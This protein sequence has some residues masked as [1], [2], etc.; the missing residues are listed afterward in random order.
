MQTTGIGARPFG[1]DGDDLTRH[2]GFQSLAVS[3]HIG[4]AAPDGDAAPDV[5]QESHHRVVPGLRFDK[6]GHRARLQ[7]GEDHRDIQ[8]VDMVGNQDQRTMF[9]HFGKLFSVDLAQHVRQAFDGGV[10]C[11]G[12]QSHALFSTGWQIRLSWAGSSSMVRLA[13]AVQMVSPSA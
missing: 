4:F 1:R 7:L 5:E 3:L 6:S 2:Q 8:E 10:D 12:C 9:R 13:P 11:P